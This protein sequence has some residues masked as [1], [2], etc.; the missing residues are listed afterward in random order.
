MSVEYTQWAIAGTLFYPIGE[1]QGHI[2]AH[3][4]K[5]HE[6]IQSNFWLRTITKNR[7]TRSIWPTNNMAYHSDVNTLDLFGKIMFNCNN[8]R[9]HIERIKNN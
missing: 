6:K 9:K 7:S 4:T 3:T 1:T 8:K 5:T 2:R